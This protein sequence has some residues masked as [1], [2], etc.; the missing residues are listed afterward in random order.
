MTLRLEYRM[1][2]RSWS[3]ASSRRRAKAPWLAS[4]AL[5]VR[6]RRRRRS[7]Q[8]LRDVILL[9][10]SGSRG[11]THVTQSTLVINIASKMLDSFILCNILISSYRR[12]TSSG[13]E[14]FTHV[15]TAS[16]WLG[17]CRK[18]MMRCERCAYFTDD[19]WLAFSVSFSKSRALPSATMVPFLT[20]ERLSRT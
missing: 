4:R 18:V 9:T 17:L 12:R 13:I 14:E 1:V 5:K 15:A 8:L 11:L 10:S 20:S 3:L 16:L 19:F 6:L 7:H 2:K